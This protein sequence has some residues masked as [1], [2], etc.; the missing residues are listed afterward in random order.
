M[1]PKKV[2]IL[3]VILVALAAFVA[4]WDMPQ[5]RKK[6]QDELAGD[7]ILDLDFEAV[8]GIELSRKDGRFTFAKRDDQWYMTEPVEDIGERW[9][10]QALVSALQYARPSRKLDELPEGYLQTFGLENPRVTLTLRTPD[11]GKTILIGA[12]HQIGNSV[13]IKPQDE[14]V[15]YLVSES[16]LSALD[17]ES[18]ELRR[19]DMLVPLETNLKINKIKIEQAGEE[20]IL[21]LA[22]KPTEINPDAAPPLPE[23]LTW[24]I[25]TSAGPTADQETMRN[26]LDKIATAKATE[27][28]GPVG[29]DPAVYG[30]DKPWLT[31]SATYGEGEQA[32][33]KTMVVGNKKE[34]GAQFYAMTQNRPFAIYIHQDTARA[35]QL[36]RFDL[37]D[38]RLLPGL[39]AGQVAILDLQ[40]AAGSFRI[41]RS[42]DGWS[43]TDGTPADGEQIDNLLVE[44]MKW[45][46]DELV[47]DR[48]GRKLARAAR[49][50]QAVTLT[51]RDADAGV[52]KRLVISGRLSAE[53]IAPAKVKS[54]SPGET[55]DK[56]QV[57][58]LI[59]GGYAD[60]V[61]LSP[62]T[63]LED[64]PQTRG[65]L[66][67]E[68]TPEPVAA[69]AEAAQESENEPSAL[70]SEGDSD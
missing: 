1:N 21:L 58:V 52:L 31:V 35:F 67:T 34:I 20:P 15:V 37:L 6:K 48:R 11:S 66:E 56:E 63:V 25:D 22:Q 53:T 49:H 40:N 26:L 44:A 46:A 70:E 41:S 60:T 57:V 3:A 28:V 24:K 30:F 13:Y 47:R 36:S 19:R 45:R 51:F 10:V 69:A 7:Q 2:L 27:F 5:S 33:T 14:Q 42:G 61:Y 18:D 9:A 4:F 59:D 29:D 32:I 16:S 65:E 62:T 39:S 8:N 23:D 43:F 12:R 38:R 50:N 54:A 68:A 64:I 17:K 55:E